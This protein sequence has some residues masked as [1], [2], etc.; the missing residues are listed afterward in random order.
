MYPSKSCSKKYQNGQSYLVWNIRQQDFQRMP[1]YQQLSLKFP[2]IKLVKVYT[3][4]S[5]GLSLFL[6]RGT[7]VLQS[8]LRQYYIKTQQRQI[9][10]ARTVDIFPL[11]IGKHLE[12]SEDPMSSVKIRI[13]DT[14]PR[15]KI[16]AA[17]KYKKIIVTPMNQ[18][19]FWSH[20]AAYCLRCIHFSLSTHFQTPL[21]VAHIFRIVHFFKH[22]FRLSTFFALYKF[23]SISLRCTNFKS[24]LYIFKHDFNVE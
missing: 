11:A 21:H 13:I 1:G 20:L 15:Q 18:K 16:L 22:M 6:G 5:G 8:W 2:S 24:I 12:R 7:S 4:I 14:D 9:K 10:L 3:P 19:L 23:S 17:N